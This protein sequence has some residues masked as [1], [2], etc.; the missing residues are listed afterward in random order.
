MC[1][2]ATGLRK[3]GV[4]RALWGVLARHRDYRFMLSAGLVSLTGD[5]ILN[6]GLAYY[7]YALTGSTLVSGS[8]LLA[9]VAPQIFLGSLAGVSS[10][11][12]IGGGPW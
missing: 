7:A 6:T 3:N 8:V 4:M 12:G 9:G 11:G 1:W 10:I 5:W 2:Y